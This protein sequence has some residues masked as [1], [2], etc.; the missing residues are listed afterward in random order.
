MTSIRAGLVGVTGYTGMELTRLLAGHPNMRLVRDG[1]GVVLGP[2]S[3]ASYYGVSAVPL[4]PET[5]VSL[6]FICLQSGM[7]KKDVQLFRSY[8]CGV[9]RRRGTACERCTSSCT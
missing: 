7:K 3:F 4:H 5:F 8:L 1:M 9:C 2:E 6:K